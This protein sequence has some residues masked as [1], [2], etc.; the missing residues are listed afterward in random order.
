MKRYALLF[1]L[2]LKSVVRPWTIVVFILVAPLLLGVFSGYGNRMNRNIDVSIAVTDETMSEASTTFKDTLRGR[3]WQLIE[4]DLATAETMLEMDDVGVTLRIGPHF[5]EFIRG[6]QN[7]AD[8]HIRMNAHNL[9]QMTIR[10]SIMLYVETQRTY[11]QYVNNTIAIQA[12]NGVDTTHSKQTFD[13]LTAYYRD[14][15]AAMPIQYV[16]RSDEPMRRTITVGDFSLQS[17]YMAVLAVI[18]TTTLNKAEKRYIAVYGASFSDTILGYLVWLF[19]GAIQISVFTLAM[20]IISRDATVFYMLLPALTTYGLLL[21]LATWLRH[22]EIDMRLYIGL[23]L[24]ILLA[25]FGGVFFPLPANILRNAAQ[26]TPLGWFYA[27]Q[28]QAATAP[29]W[30]IWTAST[31]SLLLAARSLGRQKQ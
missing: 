19:F 21:A 13:E 29:M 11:H 10:Q 24:S 31:L 20:Q 3:G 23:F 16:N 4:T 6:E 26:W 14:A 27:Y 22:L 7:E 25:L 30:L 5:D 12:R 17:L 8:L 15:E 9:M 18:A 1:W 28:L 2:K